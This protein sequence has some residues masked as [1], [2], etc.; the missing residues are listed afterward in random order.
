[1][2]KDIISQAVA[3]QQVREVIR[4]VRVD[5]NRLRD[6]LIEIDFIDA[7][8]GKRAFE[9]A[10]QSAGSRSAVIAERVVEIEEDERGRRHLWPGIRIEGIGAVDDDPVVV[11]VGDVWVGAVN[12]LI[13]IDQGI[14]IAVEHR[15]DLV[16]GRLIG[17]FV[18]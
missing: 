5:S 1:L 18:G 9:R 11:G 13:G 6:D 4:A 17:R 12:G 3:S 8:G 2:S 10:S 7:R 15:I 16:L 14:A